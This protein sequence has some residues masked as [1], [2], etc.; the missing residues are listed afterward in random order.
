MSA[1]VPI[2][3]DATTRAPN[4]TA[5]ATP[6]VADEPVNVNSCVGTVTTLNEPPTAP[7]AEASHNRR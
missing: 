5:A 4:D 1:R 7:T 6:T 3:S 2:H